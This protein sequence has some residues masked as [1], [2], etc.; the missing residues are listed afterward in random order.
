[1]D[2]AYRLFP[3]TGMDGMAGDV[4]RA[5][6]WMKDHAAA[7]GVQPEHIVMGGGSA[8]GHL[9]LLVAYA[10]ADAKANAQNEAGLTPDD[11]RGRDLSVCGVI[12]EYGP[13]DLAACYYHT[14]QHKTTRG[15]PPGPPPPKPAPS[16]PNPM[17]RLMGDSFTRF[18][19]ENGASSG[20][21][22]Q[23]LGAHPDEH[24]EA[25]ARLSP[26][27]Y[28]HPGCPPTLQ[29][30]GDLD[31]VTPPSAARRLHDRLQELCVPSLLVIYPQTDHG[32]DL[33]LPS[34][35]P[36]AQCALYDVE[37]FLAVLAGG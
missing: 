33:A 31:L 34:V 32:F 37:R 15:M 23:I 12:S 7:Y 6:A 27:T 2:V 22:I 11:V 21:F 17:Q 29:I 9:S 10:Q 8:G 28:A 24:P 4:Q 30:Q 26:V 14:N 16:R 20:A 19:M 3:E 13:T 25:Y 1:M 35:S 18:H 5:I 36:S